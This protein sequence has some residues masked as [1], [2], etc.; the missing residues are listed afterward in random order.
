[1]TFMKVHIFSIVLAL[2]PYVYFL[3]TSSYLH[4]VGEVDSSN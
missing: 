2:L 1:M 4:I 3:P